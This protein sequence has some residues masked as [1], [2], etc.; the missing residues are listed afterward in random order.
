MIIKILKELKKIFKKDKS[1]KWYY[2]RHK[3]KWDLTL[4]PDMSKNS[5][6]KE[7]NINYN[8]RYCPICKL[9]ERKYITQKNFKNIDLYSVLNKKNSIIENIKKID[10]KYERIQKINNII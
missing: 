10:K 7:V 1:H 4:N 6:I 5:P 8:Y 9:L 3:E 2:F